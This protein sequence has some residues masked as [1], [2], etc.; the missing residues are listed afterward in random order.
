MPRGLVLL[1]TLVATATEPDEGDDQAF[2][3]QHFVQLKVDPVNWKVLWKDPRTPT[4]S[5]RMA[6]FRPMSAPGNPGS[7]P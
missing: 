2:A 5:P 6:S 4:S 7:V 1:E 3:K